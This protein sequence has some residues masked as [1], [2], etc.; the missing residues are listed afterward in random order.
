MK[1]RVFWLLALVLSAPSA[2]G[3]TLP[4]KVA[5]PLV[6][7]GSDDENYLRYLQSAGLVAEYPWSV[8]SF[9]PSEVSRLAAAADS[10]PWSRRMIPVSTSPYSARILPIASSVRF[11][12]AFPFGSNDRAIWAGRGFTFSVEGGAAVVAGPVSAVIHPIAFRAENRAFAMLPNGETGNLAFAD[13]QFS[14]AVDLPQRFGPD[15]YARAELGQSTVRID[16][17]GLTAGA[18]T[19][20]MAWGP[21]GNY[22]LILGDNGPGLPHAFAGTSRPLNIGIGRAHARVIWGRLAQSAYSP[23][24]GS[25]VYASRIEA[26]TKRFATGLVAVF[27][28]RG[29]PGLEIGG[30]RFFHMIWPKDG[31]PRSYLTAAF[32]SI[33]KAGIPKLEG[34]ADERGGTSNQLASVFARWVHQRNGFEVYGEYGHDDHN[35]DLRDLVQE[36]DHSRMY[37]LGLRKVISVDSLGMSGLRAELANYQLPTLGRNRSEGAIYIHDLLRQ[38]HTIEGQPLGADVGVGSG[39]G[40]FLAWDR[41]SR[42]GKSTFSVTRTVRREKGTFYIDGIPRPHTS[43]VQYSF[44]VEQTRFLSRVELTT[45]AALVR[46]FSR[47]F[48]SDAWNLNLLLGLRYHPGM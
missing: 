19:A 27:Q 20:N 38:G 34:L 6:I 41:F 8:R 26:G 5:P 17:F 22:Q 30:A 12:S 4:P 28:P 48:A 25:D 45:G 37:A 7:V 31:L 10:Q 42:S 29:V 13:G 35:W 43:D 23:V 1:V 9:S 14:T 24:T 36:P 44:G 21:M 33:V 40:S 47:N 18:S 32:G 2:A 15:P 16:L 39:A 3:Q 11:N 46:E